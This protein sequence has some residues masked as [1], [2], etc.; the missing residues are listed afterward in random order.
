MKIK[1]ALPLL[2]LFFSLPLLAAEGLITKASDNSVDETIAKMKTA[3]ASKGIKVMAEVDHQ[4]NAASVDK[5]MGKTKLLIFGNPALGTPLMQSSITTAID[6]PMK[7]LVWR[8]ADGKVWL[9]YNDPQYFARR[10]DI[11]N[12]EEVLKKMTGALNMLTDKAAH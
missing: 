4:A 11:K 3:L 2:L 1:R 5:K 9:A 7:L 8:D 12:R 10:H 6:L